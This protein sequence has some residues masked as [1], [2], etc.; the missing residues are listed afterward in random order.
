MT[1]AG[2][3]AAAAFVVRP[4]GADLA[5]LGVAVL[6]VS[7]SAPLITAIAAPALAIAF[8][9]NLLGVAALAPVALLRGWSGLALSRREARVVALAGLALAAHF[10]TWVP[11]VTMTTV[12][13]ATALVATQP[14]WNA[15][16]ARWQGQVVPGRAWLGIG[17]AFA[18]VLV[19]TGVDASTA[20]RALLG[21]VLALV[22][23]ALA[24][25]YVA[26]GAQAR[27][28]LPTTTYAVLVYAVAAAA[29]LV[30]CLAG[31][32]AL[33]GYSAAAWW[34]IVAL[35][36]L[37]QVIGH[38]LFNRVVGT[39]GPVVVA[40]AV[41][42][43]VPGAALIAALWLGQVPPLAAA[44]AAGLIL[45]GVTLVVMVDRPEEP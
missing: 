20:G 40:L 23:G 8:W 31:G 33:R 27:R 3:G 29:L 32:V 7:A 13:A 45:A 1:Q 18:G 6:G 36:L 21:D 11:S 9:R 43:E 16:I 44:P 4:R 12:A 14:I 17:L 38:T 25:V 41:L 5:I 22:G 42:L 2:S 39:V 26:L 24:A 10:A 30:M 37:A 34:G 15:L 35:T 19:L 28:T